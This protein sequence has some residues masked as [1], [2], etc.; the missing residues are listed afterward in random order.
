[1]VW[2]FSVVYVQVGGVLKRSKQIGILMWFEEFG[3]YS[4]C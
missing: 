3:G 4:I 2:W 1:M